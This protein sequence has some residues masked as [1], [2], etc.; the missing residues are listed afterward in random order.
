VD[1]AKGDLRLKPDAE[2]FRR[3]GFR[4]IPVEE[5]V[6]YRDEYRATWPVDEGAGVAARKHALP[7]STPE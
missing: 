4:A 5:I 3:V 7:D 1:A 6:L 2:V